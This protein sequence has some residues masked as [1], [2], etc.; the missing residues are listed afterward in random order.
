M[1]IFHTGRRSSFGCQRIMGIG[2]G[3]AY[4]VTSHPPEQGPPPSDATSWGAV[5]SGF[6]QFLPRE[7]HLLS[8]P[9]RTTLAAR[10]V[11]ARGS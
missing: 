6:R 2:E 10:V 7:R 4:R 5:Q 3:A 9:T 11:C 1:A 8:P